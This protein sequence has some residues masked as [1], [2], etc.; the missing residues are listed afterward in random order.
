MTGEKK[1]KKE[2][3]QPPNRRSSSSADPPRSPTKLRSSHLISFHLISFPTRSA[4]GGRAPPALRGGAAG[5]WVQG[6]PA[7]CG[8]LAPRNDAEGQLGGPGCR[9]SPKP[10]APRQEP[11]ALSGSEGR[12]KMSSIFWGK[13]GLGVWKAG[14][15]YSGNTGV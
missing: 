2:K 11:R 10:P 9:A 14:H 6:V 8:A 4:S 12:G 3:S 13:P 1:K 7:A 15:L 5:P